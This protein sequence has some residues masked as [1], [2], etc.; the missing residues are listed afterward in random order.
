MAESMIKHSTA[1][2]QNALH[3]RQEI[4]ARTGGDRRAIEAPEL[5]DID[6]R[7]APVVLIGAGSVIAQPFVAYALAHFNVVGIVDNARAGSQEGDFRLLDDAGLKDLMQR[8]KALVGVLC[9]CSDRAVD[10]FLALWEHSERPLFSLFEA[11]RQTS[12]APALPPAFSDPA[13]I[14]RLF[15]RE[16]RWLR[17]VDEES[18]RTYLSVL[19]FRLTYDRRWVDPYRLP[20]AS[21]YFF[22]D[23]LEVGSD[24]TLVD[25]GAF[26]G[27]TIMAFAERT[28]GSYRR[29]HAFEAD[30]ANLDALNRRTGALQRIDVHPFG[31]WKSAA[32]L[33]L[34]TG[35]GATSSIGDAGTISIDVRP[36]DALDLGPVSFLKLDIEGAEIPALEGAAETIRRHKPKLS[37]AVYHNPEELAT[38]PELIASIRPDYRFRLRHHG[39]IFCDTVLYAE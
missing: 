16:E 36:L 23:A 9:C 1:E 24:E 32:E 10:H 28:K 12:L 26:D 6:L 33:R 37:L 31:L 13:V 7:S 39:P 19:L 8:E 18:R 27:D 3:A 29:I 2:L 30:P 34:S 38:I 11:M 4:L 15:E 22:T 25:G 21:M 14:A 17:F 5:R 20:L 35:Q